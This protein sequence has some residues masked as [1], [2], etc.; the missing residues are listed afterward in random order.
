MH[1]QTAS[2]KQTF[3]LFPSVP[4]KGIWGAL[5]AP[6]LAGENNICATRQAHLQTHF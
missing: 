2:P 1:I 5:L 6:P 3:K 4:S